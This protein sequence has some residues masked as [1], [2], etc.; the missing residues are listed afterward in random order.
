[1]THSRSGSRGQDNTP[2]IGY[3]ANDLTEA[4]RVRL[5]ERPVFTFAVAGGVGYVVGGGLTLGVLARLVGA[6]VRAGI[7][8]RAQRAITDWLGMESRSE[9]PRQEPRC[10]DSK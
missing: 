2:S 1:M 8:L 7:T 4:L 9:I 5:K 6:A 10:G 3:F